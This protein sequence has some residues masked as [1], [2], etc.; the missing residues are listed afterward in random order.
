MLISYL[1]TPSDLHPLI[2]P[3]GYNCRG[4]VHFED[5]PYEAAFD[6]GAAR[7]IITEE[8]LNRLRKLDSESPSSSPKIVDESQLT[9]PIPVR[10]VHRGTVIYISQ[11]VRV[12]V[13]F[14]G[15]DGQT[16]QRAIWCM[17][18]DEGTGNVPL[19]LGSLPWMH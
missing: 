12:R 13:T 11:L 3:T 19:I 15:E 17:V 18:L 14:K 10:G 7:N 2:L 6:T 5:N 1:R 8:L 4:M 16:D 9:R